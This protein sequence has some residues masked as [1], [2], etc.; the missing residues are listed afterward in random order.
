LT[1]RE[2]VEHEED[3]VDDDIEDASNGEESLDEDMDLDEEENE[4]DEEERW[5][6]RCV[7]LGESKEKARNPQA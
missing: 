7:G 4:E 5:R 2:V 1:R 3:S 6:W